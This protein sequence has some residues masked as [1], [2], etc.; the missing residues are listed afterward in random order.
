VHLPIGVLLFAILIHG[1]SLREKYAFLS[2]ALPIAYLIGTGTAILAC[3]TGLT[4]SNSGEYDEAILFNHK[5]LGIA[6]AQVSLIGLFFT[7]KRFAHYLKMISLLLL[8]LILLTGHYGGTLTHGEGYITKTKSAVVAT[9]KI[10]AALTNTQEL[11]LYTAIIQPILEEKCY[12]CHSQI[13]QKGKLRLDGEEWILKGGKDGLIIHAGDPQQSTLYHNITLDPLE[14]KHMPPKGK[15]QIT[16]EE[17]ILLEWWISSG[18]SF[19]KKIKELI[20]PIQVK[21]ILTSLEKNNQQVNTIEVPSEKVGP[22]DYNYIGALQKIGVTILPVATNSNYLTANFITLP[23][24]NDTIHTLIKNLSSNLIWLKIPSMHFS[25]GLANSIATCKALTRLSMEHSTITDNEL[26]ILNSLTQLQYLNLVGTQISLKGLLAITG[27]K[28]LKQLYIAQTS[29]TK[30]DAVVLQK[31]F[32]L[33]KIDFG[34]YTI[35]KLATDTQ[36][37]KAPVR[38]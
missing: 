3:L 18:A 12:G 13:K 1:L 22:A 34:N 10:K 7:K 36:I 31:K 14:E 26:L 27:M 29:I 33:A 32:P 15:P 24:T 5:L 38:K 21:S 6:V 17:R 30:N 20:Q 37:L 25:S 2:N 35:E 11:I 23:Q 28:N 9:K 16:E 4:L 19:N 8:I